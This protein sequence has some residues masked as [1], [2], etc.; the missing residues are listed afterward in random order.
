MFASQVDHYWPRLGFSWILSKCAASAIGTWVEM[1]HA[2][3]TELR[4]TT[5]VVTVKHTWRMLKSWPSSSLF[6]GFSFSTEHVS[7]RQVASY[8]NAKLCKLDEINVKNTLST[9]SLRLLHS[10]DELKPPPQWPAVTD[11][12]HECD[13]HPTCPAL[14]ACHWVC[15]SWVILHG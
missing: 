12:T 5:V 6:I 9:D 2:G 14:S 15:K 10:N 7:H 3:W 8:H 4:R 1:W 11:R 13:Q